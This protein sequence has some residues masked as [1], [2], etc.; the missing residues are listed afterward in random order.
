MGEIGITSNRLIMS[1]RGFLRSGLKERQE[2][3]NEKMV[4]FAVCVLAV[5]TTSHA[6]TVSELEDVVVVATRVETPVSQVGPQ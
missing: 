1:V 5:A 6:D 2:W 3:Q 4:F